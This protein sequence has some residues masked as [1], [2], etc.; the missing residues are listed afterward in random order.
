MLKPTGRVVL[1]VMSFWGSTHMFLTGVMACPPADRAKVVATGDITPENSPDNTHFCHMFKSGELRDLLER[2]GLALDFL[3]ASNA[4]STQWE[5]EL[6]EA[7][8]DAKLW[9][10]LLDLE[11]TA[12]SQPG[13][14]DMGTHLIAVAHPDHR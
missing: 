6:E 8:Q 2:N 1:S 10:W 3:S 13:C 12:S 11:V 9:N 5:G 7:R 4:L 14:W